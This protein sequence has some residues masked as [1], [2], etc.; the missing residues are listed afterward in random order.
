MRPIFLL[1]FAACTTST[2]PIA[3]EPDAGELDP[4]PD[5]TDPVAPRIPEPT[6][7]CPT[8]TNGDVTFAPAGMPPRRVRFELDTDAG[9]PGPLILY[10]HA[11]GS[12][13]YEPVYA[14]GDTL[15]AIAAAGGVI[16]A[17]HSDPSAGLFEW[18]IVNQKP[19]LDDFLLA[20]EIVACLVKSGRVD[21]RRIHSMGFSAGALQTTA[22]SFLRGDYIASVAT[23]SGGTPPQFMHPPLAPDNKLAA[24][25]FHGGVEDI[26]HGVDFA[27]ASNAYDATL[28]AAGHFTLL[29]AHGKGHAIPRDAAPSIAAFFAAHP[30]GTSP[31]PYEAALPPSLPDYCT[32]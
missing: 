24:M 4:T 29:C 14:L 16:A 11:T 30:F 25:I 15:D 28:D 23:Y 27:A 1:L 31:S 13:T 20:D 17:P 6:G 9:A 5:A 10:W 12:V 32:R 2:D 3:P 7:A 26:T 8:I 18:F 21:P 19:Q 22:M